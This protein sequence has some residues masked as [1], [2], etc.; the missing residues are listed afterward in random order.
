MAT[1]VKGTDAP[2]PLFDR[3]SYFGFMTGIV[4]LAFLGG[5]LAAVNRL[6]AYVWV[7]DATRAASAL[8]EAN[9]LRTDEFLGSHWTKLDRAGSGVTQYIPGEAFEGYTLYIDGFKPEARLIDMDGHVVHEWAK[10]FR[11]VWPDP[12]HV[13]E[14]VTERHLMWRRVHVF[15]E[16]QILAFY[17]TGRT[18][19]CGHGMV[20]LDRDSNVIWKYEGNV[21]HDLAVDHDGSIYCLTNTIRTEPHPAVEHLGRPLLEDHLVKISPDGKEEK[22]IPIFDAFANS[23]YRFVLDS[24]EPEERGDTTHTNTVSLV[25]PEFAS[26]HPLIDAGQIMVCVRN[27]NVIAVI[28]PATEAVVWAMRGIWWHPHDSAP[29]PNGNIMIFDNQKVKDGLSSR[30]MEFNPLTQELKWN[31]E[32]STESPFYSMVRGCQELL[33]NGNVLITESSRGRLLEV[34]RAKKIVWE[35][36]NPVRGGKNDSLIPVIVGAKR[37]TKAELPFLAKPVLT[38]SR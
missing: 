1:V 22:V 16:G 7:E 6:N 36:I 30:V 23:P 12:Q 2:K 28:D 37:Y 38:T 32:G 26:R 13:S 14:I 17:E 20:K 11:D 10:P 35:F 24:I 4:V 3:I 29:L 15:P 5:L 18:T 31:Y 33:P 27:A 34:T 25:G 21:H 19:P 9:E 8:W